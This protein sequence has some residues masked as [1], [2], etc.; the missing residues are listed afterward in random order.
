MNAVINTCIFMQ[1][2]HLKCVERQ[3]NVSAICSAF[4]GEVIKYTTVRRGEVSIYDSR[5]NIYGCIQPEL[6]AE[7]INS[8]RADSQG[9]FFRYLYLVATE[10]N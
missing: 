5:L 9:Y 6:L 4:T 2:Y 1:G 8:D 7:L 3:E 10:V